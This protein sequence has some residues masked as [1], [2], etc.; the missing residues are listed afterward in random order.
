MILVEEIY[1]MTAQFPVEERFGL[2]GQI[3]RAAVSVPSNIAEG[4]SR[5]GS[6]EFLHRLSIAHGSLSEVETQI[7]IAKRL[8]YISRAQQEGIEVIAAET[9]RLIILTIIARECAR[10]RLSKN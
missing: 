9:G 6:R 8:G 5:L 7:E 2:T 4:H 10:R 3:R 1:K